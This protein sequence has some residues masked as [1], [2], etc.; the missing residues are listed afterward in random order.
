[1]LIDPKFLEK[2]KEKEKSRGGGWRRIILK[3]NKIKKE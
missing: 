2:R 3:I 1:M